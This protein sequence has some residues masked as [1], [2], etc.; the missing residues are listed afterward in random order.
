MNSP[1]P[2]QQQV[3]DAIRDHIRILGFPPTL[4]ELGAMLGLRSSATVAHYLEVLEQKGYIQW[5]RGKARTLR[6]LQHE[7]AHHE[8]TG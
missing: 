5:E 8:G 3:L 1:T 7:E 6:L 2:R 4:R